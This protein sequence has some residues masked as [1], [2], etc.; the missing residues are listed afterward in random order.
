MLYITKKVKIIF[1][2]LY[3]CYRTVNLKINKNYETFSSY[4]LLLICTDFLLDSML[5][6][7]NLFY[8]TFV[9]EKLQQVQLVVISSNL[10]LWLATTWMK[11][12]ATFTTILRV[13]EK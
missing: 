13:N 11:I 6:L 1:L 4:W 12:I 7:F 3:K 5:W 9:E 2:I 8:Y 10:I